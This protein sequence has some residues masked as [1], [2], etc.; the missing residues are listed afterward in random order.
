RKFRITH[1]FH[2][3]F[4][5]EFELLEYRKSWGRDSLDFVDDQ[6][7]VSTIALSWTDAACEVDPYL[8]VS[9]GRSC[10]LPEDLVR[11]ADLVEA[12]KK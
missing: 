12:L 9:A 11:L 6:G 1:P 8:E 2:P 7:R 3:L 4:S 10:F 5:R